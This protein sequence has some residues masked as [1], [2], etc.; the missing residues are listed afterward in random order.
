VLKKAA[1]M[2]DDT[3]IPT[4]PDLESVIIDLETFVLDRVN[5]TDVKMKG[6]NASELDEAE[7]KGYIRGLWLKGMRSSRDQGNYCKALLK[8]SPGFK[9][10]KRSSAEKR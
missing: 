7:R 6:A 1:D 2:S 3:K 4:K 10:V 5:K 9:L 8:A